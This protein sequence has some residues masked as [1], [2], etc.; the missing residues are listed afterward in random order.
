VNI[1]AARLIALKAAI[2]MDGSSS[3]KATKEIAQAKI[4]AP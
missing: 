1:D 4:L 3:K 2:K